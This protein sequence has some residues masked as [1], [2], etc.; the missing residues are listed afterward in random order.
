MRVS[1]LSGKTVF[2]VGI[3]LAVMVISSLASA[4][5][6]KA[7]FLT[8]D[9]TGKA[10]NVDPNLINPWGI[11]FSATGDFWV[12]DNNTGVST[13]YNSTGVPQSLVVTVPPPAGGTGP[14]TPNGTVFNSTTD[15]V[16]TKG[17]KSGPALFLFVTEDGTMSGWNPMVD[18]TN[19]ILAV[20]NSAQGINYKGMEIGNNGTANFLYLANF[21]TGKIEVYDRNFKLTT[22]SGNFTDPH[23]PAS[24]APFNIRNINGQ[25]FISYAKQNA[26]KSDAVFG[27]GL[28]LVD[29]FDMN[30]NFVKRYLSKGKLNAPWG[31]AIAPS[32]FGTF[33][34]DML[35]GNLGD[36]KINAFDPT[37][38]ALLGTL[39]SA[40]GT[41]I[42][43]S[44][45][46]AITFGNGG[47]GGSKNV[48]YF[49]AGP[50]AYAHGRFGSITA[51]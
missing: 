29:I 23:L 3:V 9:Q 24:F 44:G 28:G 22:L 21:F 19:A 4:A 30:G 17:T 51:Q 48:L 45:L 25:L 6:Y 2:A 38:G 33:A 16:V 41:P 37:T 1:R 46:W 43:I 20:D 5:S 39:S 10:P 36:G 31:L 12:A 32:T 18:P 15:F 40:N 50:N 11:S 42:K 7:V 8:A 47:L 14:S 49:T 35:V 34:N 27:A 13:L 26:Q